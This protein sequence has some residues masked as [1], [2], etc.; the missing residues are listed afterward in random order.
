VKEWAFVQV[1]MGCILGKCGR[2]SEDAA[3]DGFVVQVV[4]VAGGGPRGL[5]RDEDVEHLDL[6]IRHFGMAEGTN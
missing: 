3:E 5:P 2:R 4:A 6:Y 1:I